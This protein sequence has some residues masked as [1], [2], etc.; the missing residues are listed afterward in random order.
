[1]LPWL[2]PGTQLVRSVLNVRYGRAASGASPAA[3]AAETLLAE[4]RIQVTVEL[5][6]YKTCIHSAQLG[7]KK[8]LAACAAVVH[9]LWYEH[10]ADVSEPI[11]PC[12]PSDSFCVATN[13]TEKHPLLVIGGRQCCAYEDALFQQK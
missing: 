5:R 6:V 12:H 1:M 3:A 13:A 9:L 4:V 10:C 8:S 11:S 7:V 2:A